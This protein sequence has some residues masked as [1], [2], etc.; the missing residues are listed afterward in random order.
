MQRE[1]YTCRVKH[2][3]IMYILKPNVEY[4]GMYQRYIA[5]NNFLILHAEKIIQ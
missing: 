5:L 1:Q 3:W 2:F 4:L